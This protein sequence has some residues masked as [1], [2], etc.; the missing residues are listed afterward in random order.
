ME[1]RRRTTVR[2]QWLDILLVACLLSTMAAAEV[3]FLNFTSGPETAA[4]LLSAA[5]GVSV[6]D[7]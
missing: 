5:E 1:V 3:V 7:R 6:S 2:R 4:A